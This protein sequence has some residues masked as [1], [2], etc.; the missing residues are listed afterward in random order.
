MVIVGDNL[1]Q[2]VQQYGIIDDINC[3]EEFSISL[4][5]DRVIYM[6]RKA[7]K[8]INIEYDKQN[9]EKLY[10]KVIIE[11]GIVKLKPHS[12]ILACSCQV[13]SI[14][15]GYIGFIQTKGSLARHF[16]MVH[17][18][19]AQIEPGFSGKI[20]FEIVNLSDFTI[21]IAVNSKVS[22]LFIHKCSMVTNNG[23]SGKYNNSTEP[24]IP[25]PHINYFE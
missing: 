21:D 16:V 9:V 23:Y 4:G 13:V 10:K 20:T 14:P 15:L 19:D 2:L 22:Q 17:M 24:T 12:I 3:V 6:P 25:S 18:C 5:I 1:K 7:H 11:D 8:D